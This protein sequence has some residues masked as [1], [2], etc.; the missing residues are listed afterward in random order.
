M[1]LKKM[2]EDNLK[3]EKERLDTIKM[4]EYKLDKISLEQRIKLDE[5]Q[6]EVRVKEKLSQA[7]KN[8]E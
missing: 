2:H 8:V 3:K 4:Y 7:V 5:A 6:D 1:K